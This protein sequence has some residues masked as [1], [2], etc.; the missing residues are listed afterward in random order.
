MSI[1]NELSLNK[2]LR[3]YELKHYTFV[4]ENGKIT[5]MLITI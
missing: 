4:I 5:E 1:F 2:L 3:C